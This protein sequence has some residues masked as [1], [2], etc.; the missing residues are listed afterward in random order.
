[1]VGAIL[2]VG[3]RNKRDSRVKSLVYGI[4]FT[5]HKVDTI[6]LHYRL[7]SFPLRLTTSP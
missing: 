6:A 7:R 5:R 2:L 1:M 4:D 3:G